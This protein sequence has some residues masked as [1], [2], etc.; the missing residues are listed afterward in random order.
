M[1]LVIGSLL[2]AVLTMLVLPM[3]GEYGGHN[4]SFAIFRNM[5]QND[6]R[7]PTSWDDI[8]PYHKDPLL[9]MRSTVIVRQFWDVNWNVDPH[10]LYK[11]SE[12]TPRPTISPE[13]RVLPV[14]FN[15]GWYPKDGPVTRWVLSPLLKLKL[16]WKEELPATPA[17][18]APAP[19]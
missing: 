18:S 16:D 14:V 3:Y 13:D 6:G 4:I 17:I 1:R 8:E 19:R 11:E 15:R 5:E 10:Q 9:P 2:L 7:W 12:A